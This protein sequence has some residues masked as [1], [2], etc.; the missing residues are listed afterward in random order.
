MCFTEA[1]EL[2]NQ[3]QQTQQA[4]NGSGMFQL[5]PG[6]LNMDVKMQVDATPLN[7]QQTMD[8]KEAL[9]QTQM[10]QHSGNME[11]PLSMGDLNQQVLNTPVTMINTPVSLESPIFQQRVITKQE[12]IDNILQQGTQVM[13]QQASNPMIQGSNPIMQQQR[14]HAIPDH[15]NVNT[16]NQQQGFGLNLSNLLS[17]GSITVSQIE[18]DKILNAGPNSNARVENINTATPELMPSHPSGT[19][20]TNTQPPQQLSRQNSNNSLTSVCSN[21]FNSQANILDVSHDLA[22]I[23]QDAKKDHPENID[24]MAEA[25]LNVSA[26]SVL[27]PMY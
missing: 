1:L 7:G 20:V 17:Q 4:E 24:K 11:N 23:L 12:T 6:T 14:T 27:K 2:N 3:I 10:M 18:M 13:Q 9:I 15:A 26:S 5:P 21:S 19:M 25:I 22:N 8:T 16:G